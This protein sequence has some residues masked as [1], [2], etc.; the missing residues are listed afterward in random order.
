MSEFLVH[1]KGEVVH[2]NEKKHTYVIEADSLE[3]AQKIGREVFLEEY[4]ENIS[5]EIIVNTKKFN[6]TMLILLSLFLMS[7]AIFLSFIPWFTENSHTPIII[8][9]DLTSIIFSVLFYVAFLLRFKGIAN[10]EPLKDF[11]LSAV[12]ILLFSSFINIILVNKTFTILNFELS[13][14]SRTIMIIAVILSWIGLK[15]SS[16]ICMLFIIGL[17]LLNLNNLS[18]AMKIYGVLYGMLSF[19]GIF[20]YALAEPSI[21]DSIPILQESMFKNS[22]VIKSNVKKLKKDSISVRNKIQLFKN[23]RRER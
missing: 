15:S 16:A 20:S 14:D 1:T 3:E 19:F 7:A 21:I 18:E 6:R 8:S 5:S 4:G 22:R 9:P 12:F 23:N 2:S 13:V 17:G 10:I 11:L